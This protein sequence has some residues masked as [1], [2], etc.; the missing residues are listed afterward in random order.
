MNSC[1]S[2]EV[3]SRAANL[4]STR[5]Q[6]STDKHAVWLATIVARHSEITPDDRAAI[7]CGISP[8]SASARPI[9]RAARCGDSLRA[10]ASCPLIPF[11]RSRAGTPAAF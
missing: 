2:D 8:T 9:S 3:S 1:R 5:L 6:S 4:A 10:N 7:V 11:P